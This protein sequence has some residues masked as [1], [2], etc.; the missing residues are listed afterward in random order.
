MKYIFPVAAFFCINVSAQ[1]RDS[2]TVYGTAKPSA[3]DFVPTVSELSGAKLKRKRQSTVGETLSRETGVSATQFGPNASRPVIR[4]MEGDRVR[5]LQNGTGVLDASSASQDHAVAIDPLV[6]DRIEIVRGPAALLYG[7]NAM[8]GVVNL[9]TTRIPEERPENFEGKAEARL[10]NVDQGRSLGAVFKKSLGSKWVAHVDASGRASEDYQVPGYARTE[11]ERA[12]DP[13]DPEESG[14]VYN[15]FNRG[16]SQALGASYIADNGF[17]GASFSNYDSRYGTVAERPVMIDLNQQ[18]FD[19]GGELRAWSVFRSVRFKNTYS[20][21]EH[22]EIEDGE[23]GTTFRNEGDE[24]R[25]DFKHHPILGFAGVFGA[26]FNTFDFTAQGDEAFLP[27]T[28]NQTY[29]LFMF[30]EREEGKFRPS[31]GGRLDAYEVTSKDH[32]TFGPSENKTFSGGSASLGFLYQFSEAHAISLNGAY[33]ERAPNYQELFAD[34]RHVATRQFERGD[35]SLGK[36]QSQSLELSYRYKSEATQ[37]RLGVFVQDFNRYISL[38]PTGVDDGDPTEP[39]EIFEYRAVDARFYGAEFE[40]RHKLADTVLGGELEAEFK[41]DLVRAR[42]RSTQ[43]DLPRITP[44]RETVGLLY[45]TGAWAGDIQIERT[46][47]QTRAAPGES[48]TD[49]YTLFGFGVERTF[50][51][52]TS[53]WNLFARVNNVFDEEA[54]NH[55]SVLKDLGPLPGRNVSIG[56][57]TAF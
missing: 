13:L 4:G 9:E 37:A 38:A 1:T 14:R 29:S 33:T 20:T 2:I 41:A 34:G 5:M 45:R 6:I 8:G 26:Q 54:R 3:L 27:S 17:V 18:R 57:Q 31:F 21:Y 22:Q 30:E 11:A 23:V 19:V 32:A 7:S 46:E 36:E 28:S 52:Q 53:H 51:S 12:A 43:T 48:K 16:N 35:T 49:E 24:A 25:V 40:F 15:S 50:A 56:L 47:R 42:D 10:S 55:V 44:G 39:F